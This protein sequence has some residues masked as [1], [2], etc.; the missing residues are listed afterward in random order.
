METDSASPEDS[1]QA[2][3]GEASGEE[4]EEDTQDNTVGNISS[5]AEGHSLSVD[6]TL[7]NTADNTSDKS[8]DIPSDKIVDNT[9]DSTVDNTSDT[10]R[11]KGDNRVDTGREDGGGRGSSDN[12]GEDKLS[13]KDGDST[14]REEVK[15]AANI[16]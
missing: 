14:G 7:D 2:R 13:I 16:A 3:T 9:L 6:S 12:A 1:D 10:E 5:N 8:A 4:R 15:P 11:L